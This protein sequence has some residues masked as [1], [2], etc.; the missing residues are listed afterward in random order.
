MKK[1]VLSGLCLLLCATLSAQFKQNPDAPYKLN[2]WSSAAI[3]ATG[4]AGNLIG[5]K[6]LDVK[7][8]VTA[9]EAVSLSM[10]DVN[11]FDDFVFRYP[12]SGFDA[13]QT[14]S[15]ITMFSTVLLPAALLI[16]KDIRSWWLD[17][18]LLYFKTHAI[19]A[20]IYAWGIPHLVDRYRPLVYYED[21]PMG[22]RT[23]NRKA[24][25]FFSG[26][27]S[28]TATGSFFLASVVADNL[29][30]K[31]KWIAYAAGALPPAFVALDR[32]RAGK[33]FVSDVIVGYIIG[34]S[35]GILVPKL[36]R[37]DYRKRLENKRNLKRSS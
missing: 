27:V 20:N 12:S 24:N 23:G 8:R 26:H 35:V 28:T 2:R 4:F 21:L 17:Y 33:H 10:D 34:G 11:S 19:G 1:L 14:R 5:L 6:V 3:T 18:S 15:D 31:N 37:S 13:A 7:S 36:H 9:A 22:L 25:S 29:M 30:E 16:H 32:M